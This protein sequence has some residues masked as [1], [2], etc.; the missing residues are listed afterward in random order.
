[1]SVLTVSWQC[2]ELPSI[3]AVLTVPVK[4]LTR[5]VLGGAGEPFMRGQLIPL[6]HNLANCP[7]QFIYPELLRVKIDV[8]GILC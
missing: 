3:L 8:I 2:L 7:V 6:I 1:M 4:A 5:L